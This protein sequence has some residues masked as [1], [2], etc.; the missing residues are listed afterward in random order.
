MQIE[1]EANHMLGEDILEITVNK[2]FF[3]R[4]K[5]ELLDR[6]HI[7]NMGG[8]DVVQ[9]TPQSIEEFNNWDETEVYLPCGKVLIRSV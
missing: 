9:G 8:F 4:L 3:D 5:M 2:R 7:V 6:R 1:L